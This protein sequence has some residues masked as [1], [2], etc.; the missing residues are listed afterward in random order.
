MRIEMDYG[1]VCARHVAIRKNIWALL[2]LKK[3]S[4]RM[5]K[6]RDFWN[7]LWGGQKEA[8]NN[9]A[10]VPFMITRDMRQRLYDLNYT[11]V[12]VDSM[13]PDFAW[14]ILNKCER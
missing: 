9:G 13:T 1:V 5:G 14:E 4:K 7:N 2:A 6:I 12:E 8:T 10:K 3:E 11:R